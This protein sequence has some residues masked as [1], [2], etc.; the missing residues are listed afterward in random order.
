LFPSVLRYG[1]A[2]FVVMLQ[3]ETDQQPCVVDN[4]QW[5]VLDNC[6]WRC[7]D[8]NTPLPATLTIDPCCR[9]LPLAPHRARPEDPGAHPHRH[10][11]CKS[12]HQC[13]CVSACWKS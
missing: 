12:K 2:D 11:W 13:E 7:D 5:P 3:W 8:T 1:V 10:F 9:C 6:W 4:Y